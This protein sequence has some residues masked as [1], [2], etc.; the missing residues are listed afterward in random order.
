MYRLFKPEK[1]SAESAYQGTDKNHVTC[2]IER[3]GLWEELEIR[4]HHYR[5][6][7]LS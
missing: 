3:D 5:G 6:L 7:P 1:K 2:D 4:V